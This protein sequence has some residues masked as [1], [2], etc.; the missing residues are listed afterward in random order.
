[1]EYGSQPKHCEKNLNDEKTQAANNAKL[2]KKLNQVSRGI[3]E[4]EL[5]KAEIEYNEPIIVGFVII[6]PAKLE[7]LELYYNFFTKF[8]DVNKFEQLE[9][10]TV[11]VYLALA[12]KEMED[13]NRP[14]MKA[15]WE[16]L[17]PKDC[18][19]SFT[20]DAVAKF[21]LQNYNDKPKKNVTGQSLDSSKSNSDAQRCHVFVVKITHSMMLSQTNTNSVVK[22]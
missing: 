14:K 20:A 16:C 19:N 2:L 8:C 3:D 17:W 10:D 7:K 18:T 11:S 6:Q 4:V 22:L 13:F 21:F 12:E 5:V 15:E 9:M 1:M